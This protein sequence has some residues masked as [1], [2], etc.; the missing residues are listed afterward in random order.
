[1]EKTFSATDT[2][3]VASSNALSS[4]ARGGFSGLPAILWFWRPVTGENGTTLDSALLR[5][6][7]LPVEVSEKLTILN[8]LNNLQWI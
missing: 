2:R 5:R 8:E 4:K 1:M 7:M 6:Y 3:A